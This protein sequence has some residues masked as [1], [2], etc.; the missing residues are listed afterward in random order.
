[1]AEAPGFLEDQ[2]RQAL[3]GLPHVRQVAFGVP[4]FRTN[5]HTFAVIW[6]G[7]RLGLCFQAEAP[8]REL[9]AL[10]GADPWVPSRRH[11]PAARA[12]LLPPDRVEDLDWLTP[13]VRRAWDAAQAAPPKA[14][15]RR[16]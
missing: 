14:R 3:A 9:L 12:A 11:P 13:W 2:L 4:L 1:M 5:G 8:A 10:P 6:E 16:K 7:E 15:P